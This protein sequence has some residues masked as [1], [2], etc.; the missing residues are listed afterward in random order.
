MAKI[1]C[2]ANILNTESVRQQI[3][4]GVITKDQVAGIV[5][6]MKELKKKPN[7]AQNA[8]KYRK[9]TA[10]QD[11]Y[12]SLQEAN[13]IVKKVEVENFV[14]ESK[15][16]DSDQP[17]KIF[18]ALVESPDFNLKG[19]KDSFMNR[20][21]GRQKYNYQVLR[22]NLGEDWKLAQDK[23]NHRD[24]VVAMDNANKGKSNAEYP[25]E[26]QNI[27]EGLRKTNKFMIT[28]L[29]SAGI[30]VRERSDYI[31]R[32]THDV[33]KLAGAKAEDWI[34]FTHSKVDLEKTF[35]DVVDIDKQKEIL[36]EIYARIVDGE[37]RSGVGDLGRKRSIHFK[38]GD[39][40]FDY[41]EKFGEGTIIDAIQ[42]SLDTAARTEAM[43]HKF[44]PDPKK[45]W[46]HIENFVGEKVKEKHGAKSH[47]KY[48]NQN[49]FGQKNFRDNLKQEV[50]GYDYHPAKNTVVKILQS[51][52]AISG[53]SKL[54]NAITST[55]TDTPLTI[56]NYVAK[57]GK[58]PVQAHLDYA[59]GYTKSFTRGQREKTYKVISM[60]YDNELATRVD[61][62]DGVTGVMKKITDKVMMMTGLNET[63]KINRTNGAILAQ[64][65]VGEYKGKAFADVDPALKAELENF[66]I[67]EKDWDNLI[68]DVDETT[69]LGLVTPEKIT[70]RKLQSK[71]LAYVSHNSDIASPQSG[72]RTRANMRQ[73]LSPNT[74]AGAALNVMTQFKS[75]SVQIGRVI[76]EISLANPEVNATTMGKGLRNTGNLSM[77]GMVMTEGFIAASIGLVMRD[78]SQGKTPRDMSKK[79]NILEAINRGVLPLQYQYIIDTVK[80]ENANIGRS[81]TKGLAGPVFGQID[82]VARIA[83]KIFTGKKVGKESL[84]FVVNNFPLIK[85]PLVMPLVNKAFLTELNEYMSP[86]SKAK[87]N[88]KMR[89]R[90]QEYLHEFWE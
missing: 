21:N 89:E 90:G 65:A 35:G 22:N 43:Y 61:M 23:S 51:L 79:E 31:F 55:L 40:L 50:F 59:S 68:A 80:G 66:N 41:H 19:G 4:D 29:E 58:N 74:T 81:V 28:D 32:Q 2:V 63:T 52:Q 67:T 17:T 8:K 36:G 64:V 54:Q 46:D 70:D 9:A 76:K 16:I 18:E 86:G 24:M 53:M 57:T 44:G 3:I 88:K 30:I 48:M 45:M 7:Y 25:K 75:F 5:E 87:V 49:I 85:N 27:A 72:A 42:R 71:Y 14:I 6:T 20:M 84:N 83:S 38:D 78:L 62:A 56:A 34:D 11:A 60:C 33:A 1:D 13:A 12:A 47:A 15:L 37:Y 69:G 82:D 39:S 77:F 10:E 73:G 26:I